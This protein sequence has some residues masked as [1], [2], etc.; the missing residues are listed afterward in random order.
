M[1]ILQVKTANDFN[2][3]IV[4]AGHILLWHEIAGDGT[5]SQHWKKSNGTFGEIASGGSSSGG[6]DVLALLAQN[7][8]NDMTSRVE[9]AQVLSATMLEVFSDDSGLDLVNSIN[10]MMGYGVDDGS[11]VVIPLNA[12]PFVDISPNEMALT[13][14][15]NLELSSGAFGQA[16]LFTQASTGPE[17]IKISGVNGMVVDGDFT[18]EIVARMPT[19]NGILAM[20]SSPARKIEIYHYNDQSMMQFNGSYYGSAGLINDTTYHFLARRRNGIIYFHRNGVVIGTGANTSSIVMEPLLIGAQ[21]EGGS[22]PFLGTLENFRF[23]NGEDKTTDPLD[24]VY[25]PEGETTFTPPTKSYNAFNNKLRPTETVPGTPDSMT[26]ISASITDNIAVPTEAEVIA[27][28][29]SAGANGTDWKILVE[30]TAGTWKEVPMSVSQDFGSNRKLWRGLVALDAT[31]TSR[32]YKVMT[33]NHTV[34]A[35]YR[36]FYNW[37]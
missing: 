2:N 13:A 16:P 21:T 12:K 15:D 1:Q 4:P 18:F 22:M 36:L 24:P 10:L 17:F 30:E 26:V 9:S 3:A 23:V 14:T 11:T 20:I 34:F 28:I 25:I 35:M 33:F 29:V 32:R 37:R 19:V 7:F 5:V 6:I 31:G 8:F 27:E